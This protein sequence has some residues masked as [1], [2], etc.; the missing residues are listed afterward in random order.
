MK[1]QRKKEDSRRYDPRIN[2]QIPPRKDHGSCRY[3]R[4]IARKSG[5]DVASGR[6]L[7]DLSH[8]EVLAA[9]GLRSSTVN[10]SVALGGSILVTTSEVVDHFSIELLDGLGLATAGVAALATTLGAA[11]LALALCPG[12]GVVGVVGVVVLVAGA[13][14]SLATSCRLRLRL[15]TI[16]YLA[17]CQFIEGI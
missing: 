14:A 7:R 10:G 15:M 17:R 16:G 5:D 1:K 11:S 8:A 12:V 4:A 3:P 2:Y 9:V 13:L 6:R